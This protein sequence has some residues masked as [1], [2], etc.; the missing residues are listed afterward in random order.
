MSILSFPDDRNRLTSSHHH[1][2]TSTSLEPP[3]APLDKPKANFK[4]TKTV[5]PTDLTE[6][7]KLD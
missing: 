3:G 6:C 7:D 1:R 2:L 5:F 4:L